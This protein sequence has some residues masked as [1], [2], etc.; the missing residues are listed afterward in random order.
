LT[1]RRGHRKVREEVTAM[2][3]LVT[4]V[5]ATVLAAPPAAPL[6]ALDATRAW[7]DA[8]GHEILAEFVDM[9]SVPNVASDHVNIRRNAVLIAGA[10][11]RR[12]VAMEVLEVPG[13]PPIIVGR[14]DAPDAERT[15]GIYVHYDGQPVEPA[16]WTYGPWEPTLCTRALEAGGVARGLPAAGEL[17]DPEWRL[18]AR[19]AGDDKAPLMA[20]LAA[21]DALRA[22]DLPVTSN[23]RFL[24]EG[25][26]EAGSPHLHEYLRAHRDLLEADVWLICD[27][28]VHQSRRPQLVFGVRGITALE[29]TVYGATRYLHSGH[30]GNWA[31]NPA[32]ELS[33]LLA[34]MT[35]DEGR[36]TIEGFY[37][38]VAPL[39]ASDREALA[40]IPDFDDGIRREL[41]LAES[42]G[43]PGTT[44]AEQIL[45]PSLNV[46]GFVGGTVGDEARNVIPNAATAS[47]DVRLVKG[48]D[49]AVMLDRI[50]DHI[51]RAGWHIVR[52][53]PDMT[54]R[55]AHPR[56]ARV[57]RHGGYRASRS[58]TDHPLVGPLSAAAAAAADEAVVLT[59]TMGGSLPLYLF[60]DLLGAPT[61]IVPIANHDDNQHAPDENLRIAN[62]WYG[63][64]L[65][66]GV[67]TMEP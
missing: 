49:P 14:I 31:P 44:L 66:G 30:Y 24:F 62:L 58:A 48:N 5:L 39:S 67:L 9:L 54:T 59:P 28:P 55:L 18:Y 36:V 46:N 64:D 16:R 34:G 1:N 38:D 43:G 57:V 27:G 2:S 45:L 29:I 26:E 42:K 33:R 20:L 17:I 25:E 35:D 32:M 15:I 63:I 23:V 8:H 11:E 37:D 22:A 4:L 56:L 12:G 41:G 60:E 51:R 3:T 53:A 40:T 61:I 21:L 19:A 6:D 65:M 47:I 13:A 52:E 50:E 10:F 7:R